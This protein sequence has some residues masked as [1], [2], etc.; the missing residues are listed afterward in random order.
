MAYFKIVI[1]KKDVFFI[2]KLES[3][4]EE[5][6]TIK[7]MQTLYSLYLFCAVIDCYNLDIS[8][9]QLPEMTNPERLSFPV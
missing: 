9:R 2:K 5:R 7:K 1:K 4:A 8:L 6:H 3:N